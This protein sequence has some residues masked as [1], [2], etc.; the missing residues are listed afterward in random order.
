[1]LRTIEA[2]CGSSPSRAPETHLAPLHLLQSPPVGRT[3]APFLS[4]WPWLVPRCA[5][6]WC[7]MVASPGRLWCAS[8][9]GP[10]VRFPRSARPL[11]PLDN[12]LMLPIRADT[13]NRHWQRPTGNRVRTGFR[14][15][16]R[17][18]AAKLGWNSVAASRQRLLPRSPRCSTTEGF[19][20][21][22]L[23]RVFS[24]TG[25]S[26]LWPVIMDQAAFRS[27]QNHNTRPIW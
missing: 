3:A 14:L 4:S 26:L 19:R 5:R 20:R 17:L 12:K 9:A 25:I 21:T 7:P 22:R 24:F 23:W 8:H 18:D 13:T 10:C 16:T 11:H 2:A 15:K 1:L 6:C 27:L